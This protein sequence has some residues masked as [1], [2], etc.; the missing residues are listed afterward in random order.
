MK[1]KL[2]P[3]RIPLIFACLLCILIV[4]G[5]S[6]TINGTVRSET[7][8]PLPGVTVSSSQSNATQTDAEGKFRLQVP[9][10]NAT[11]VFSSVGYVAQ[12]VYL[13]GRTSLNISL[14]ANVGELNE[15]VVT[16]IGIQRQKKSLGY[17]TQVI[18]GEELTTA[19]ETN[20]ANS[21][22]GKVAGVF[23][24]PANTGP[25][26]STF[27]SIRGVSSFNSGRTKPLIVVDGVPIDNTTINQPDIF[28]SRGINRDYGDGIGNILPDDIE[29][30]TVLKGPN[31]AALYGSRGAAGVILITTKK[32]QAGRKFGIDVNSNATFERPNVLPQY[33]EV[34]GGGYDDNYAMFGTTT[35]DG[36]EVSVFPSWLT[37]HWGGKYDGRPIQLEMWPEAG[38]VTYSPSGEDNIRKFYR[39]GATYTNT[40]GI[41][42]GTDRLNYRLSL[43]DLRNTGIVPLSSINRKTINL[44]LG[45]NATDKLYF[46][47]KVNYIK[48][49]GNGRP[50]NGLDINTVTYSLNRIPAFINIDMLKNYKSPD[51]RSYNWADG[52]PFNPYWVINE[53]PSHDTRDRMIGYVLGRYNFNSWLTLQART[54]TDF[55]NDQRHSQINVG[56]PTSSLV[57]GQLLDQQISVRED[58]SDVL[59]TASGN[60]SSDFTGSFSVGANHMNRNFNLVS[61]EGYNMNIPGIY[62]IVNAGLVFPTNTVNKKQINSVF[63]AAQIGYKNYLFVDITGRNDWSSTLGQDNYAFFYPSVSTSFVFTDALKLPATVLNYGKLRLSY[64]QGGKDGDPYQ[65]KIGYS[66]LTNNYRG[67]QFGRIRSDVPEINL[68]NE[69]TTSVEVGTELKFFNNRIGIDF[70]Y[71]DSR[72]KN[73]ILPVDISPAT[74]FAAKIAN[75]GEIRNRGIEIMLNLVPVQSKN[76]TWDML[77]NF[78]RN[79]SEVMSLAEG[80]DA[81]SLISTEE[82]A[83]EARPGLPYGN[84]V[85]Y[86]FKRTPTGEKWLT[87][88]G[89]YQH[90]DTLSVL[91]NMQPDFIGGLTNTF[92]FK[93][94]TL[95]ALIDFRIGGEI[96]S[97]S[98]ATQTYSGTAKYTENG[99]NLI[100]DGV[101]EGPDGKFTKSTI[102]VGR[103]NYYTSMGWG[104][105]SE[106]FVLPADYVALR[107]LSIGYTIGKF[108]KGTVL[109]NARLSVVGRNLFYIYRDSEF[110]TL[111]ISPENA[112]NS[113]TTAQGFEVPT[114]PT[115]RSLG[116]N[117]SFSF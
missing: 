23:I 81:I 72:T 59:L 21:L 92:T 41:S 113:S 104:N 3:K 7:N 78:S 79:R 95:S 57:R 6:V 83:I 19:R 93:G 17:T 87:A 34:W 55:Y 86:G 100:S 107:E 98:K 8:A 106:A 16:A 46:E 76:F 66:L 47:G 70:T 10:K 99:D 18:K 91:G 36:Q 54:G 40:V 48:N 65:T 12:T 62:N 67:Q 20:V 73:Q 82:I 60:L 43:S 109:N 45:F 112:F 88:N 44:R 33:Q 105:I 31:G 38:L 39:T 14:K 69:L 37:D 51:G 96:F 28:N 11:V 71:Y 4:H 77:L 13:D 53:M 80:I 94:F 61:V 1:R 26:G 56:T 2:L 75:A 117:L 85:G 22:K 49:D 116:V 84:I 89:I 68:K 115:T 97:Y 5:Q 102:V 29:N 42:G 52:R 27:I 30:I 9:D 110:K 64:A 101:I 63:A 58:N 25:G 111:G 32:G 74:G 50:A 108:F 114:A 15:V 35:V 103:M 24:S 90:D